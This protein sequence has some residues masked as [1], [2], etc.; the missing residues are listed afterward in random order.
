MEVLCNGHMYY[1][2]VETFNTIRS[3]SSSRDF[4][5]VHA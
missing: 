2:K 3:R 4:H 5:V 1:L